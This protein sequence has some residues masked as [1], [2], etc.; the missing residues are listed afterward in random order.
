MMI[1][2]RVNI[3]PNCDFKV[4]QSIPHIFRLNISVDFTSKPGFDTAL[5]AYLT[6]RKAGVFSEVITAQASGNLFYRTGGGI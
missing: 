4:I 2:P 5:R 1:R 3:K 6:R